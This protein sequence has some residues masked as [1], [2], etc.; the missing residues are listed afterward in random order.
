[1]M[2]KGLT[3]NQLKIIAMII[4][5]IDHVGMV[6]FPGQRIFRIIGRLAYPIFA[7]MIAEG[8]CYTRSYGRYLGTMAAMAAVYQVVY[9]LVSWGSLY[10][11]ILVTFSLSIGLIFLCKMAMEKN[12]FL[13]CLAV[14]G[15]I[16]LTFFLTEVLPGM[17]P[18]TDY[19]VD[20]GFWGVMLPVLVYLGKN[21]MQK[22]CICAGVLLILSGGVTNI[23]MWSLL[24]VALLALYNGQRGKW[25]MKY[26][27][28]IYYPLHLVVIYF[29]A[30][31]RIYC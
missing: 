30:L 26:F 2:K 23:Q 7:Y 4:M 5:T 8:C 1:M 29:I 9:F 13:S 25:K 28:Y 15:G 16:C 14:G 21:K 17:L 18:G 20:Y 24:S 31:L 22:L 19:A 27:F 11:C 6:L 10:Q 3:G 12:N